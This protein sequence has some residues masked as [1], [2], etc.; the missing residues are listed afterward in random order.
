MRLENGARGGGM[1]WWT[2][3][4]CLSLE[5]IESVESIECIEPRSF[6]R[7][8]APSTDSFSCGTPSS[9]L[10]R[11]ATRS[12]K[13]FVFFFSA[14]TD[15]K[16]KGK[17]EGE[18][19]RKAS[20]ALVERHT[21]GTATVEAEWREQGWIDDDDEGG[22]RGKEGVPDFPPP[23]GAGWRVISRTWTGLTLWQ[24]RTLEQ[25][26]HIGRVSRTSRTVWMDHDGEESE[27][28]SVGVRG[29]ATRVC[30]ILCRRAAGQRQ[31]VATSQPLPLPL[32][33][34]LTS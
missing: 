16:C 4:C 5:S 3:G 22:V 14:R 18:M 7:S 21:R 15:A 17:R 26:C 11:R 28:D 30:C 8:L 25:G 31:V 12:T 32:P 20:R 9:S 10:R 13:L 19:G 24:R 33:L 1:G 2:G 6:A 29:R 23:V 34:S 27:S